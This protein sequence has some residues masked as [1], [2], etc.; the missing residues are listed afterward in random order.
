MARSSV[1]IGMVRTGNTDEARPPLELGLFCEAQWPRLVATLAFLVRDVVTAEDLAQETLTRACQHWSKLAA[2]D[3]P[4]VWL[5]RVAVNLA[6]S[7]NRREVGR[8]R[9]VAALTDSQST[10]SD[11]TIEMAL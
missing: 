4:G 6:R 10:P 2:M 8:S 7:H 9:A 5:H 11:P 1:C 3:Y